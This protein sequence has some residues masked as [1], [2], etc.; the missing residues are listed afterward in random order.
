MGGPLL[1]QHGANPRW[2]LF[3]VGGK[4]YK[5]AAWTS[6]AFSA[7]QMMSALDSIRLTCI[8]PVTG[9]PVAS[10]V[11]ELF[12]MVQGKAGSFWQHNGEPV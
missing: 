9:D 1:Y 4:I 6:V 7:S 2:Q 11:T 8:L 3:A 12:R 10:A 5:P